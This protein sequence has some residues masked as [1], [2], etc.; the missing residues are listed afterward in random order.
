MDWDQL[1]SS[2][3]NKVETKMA[4]IAKRL[5]DS[6]LEEEYYNAENESKRQVFEKEMRRRGLL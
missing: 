6:Q 4:S 5:T 2:I 1:C 3:N